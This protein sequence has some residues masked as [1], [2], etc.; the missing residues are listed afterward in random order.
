MFE[1]IIS[2][3]MNVF[4]PGFSMLEREFERE[5]PPMPFR[6]DIRDNGDAYVLEA[7]LPGMKKEDISIDVKDGRLRIHATRPMPAAGEPGYVRRERSARSYA[8][9]FSLDGI[10]EA[11]IQ[12]S[13]EAGVLSVRMP[14]AK[15]EEPEVRHIDIN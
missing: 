4:F 11:G 1:P 7:D 12:A 14:K 13:Y 3:V 8:R 15:P 9:S 6:S 10:D 2:D 5:I